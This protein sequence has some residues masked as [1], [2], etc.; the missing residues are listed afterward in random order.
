VLPRRLGA[1]F[2]LE[3]LFLV[4]LALGAG[5]AHLRPLYIVA[6]MAAAWLLVA[7]A[8]LAAARIER[9]PVSYLLPQAAANAEEE[10]DA[11]AVFGPRPEERTV[12][13]PPERVPEPDEEPPRHVDEDVGAPALEE[14]PEPAPAPALEREP[15][16]QPIGELEPEPIVELEPEPEPEPFAFDRPAA[17]NEAAAAPLQPEEEA[18][19]EPEP[20]QQP[21]DE[22]EPEP[23]VEPE[24]VPEAEP[25][26]IDELEPEREPFALDRHPAAWGEAPAAPV[27]AEEEA[28]PESEPQPTDELQ[29]AALLEPE[30]SPEPV[31]EP[32]PEPEPI[33]EVEPEPAH[34]ALDRVAAWAEA[35]P[36]PLRAEEEAQPEPPRPRRLRSLLRRKEPEV[37]PLPTSPP[38]H[39]K[40][41]PRRPAEEPSRASEEVA[42]LFGSE[43]DPAKSEETRS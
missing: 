18:Q 40:L 34:F 12:V 36:A 20:G 4:L 2:A 31:P 8:E 29:P 23:I 32:E 42:E 1:R 28:E 33:A 41:L 27:R 24:P 17:W 10:E 13:A 7:L 15:E 14:P 26:L 11:Q 22:P 6:V 37:E 43:D 35:P 25:D 5:L 38:R 16:P 30:P 3:A 39:V 9:S 21:I 19:R